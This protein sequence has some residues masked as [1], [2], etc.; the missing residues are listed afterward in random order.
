ML[1]ITKISVLFILFAFLQLYAQTPEEFIQKAEE[2]YR[3]NKLAEAVQLMEQAIQKYPD[4][5][6][7]YSYL[8]LYRGSQA[9][10]TQNF[11]EAGRLVGVGF[12]ML[13]KGV[14]LDSNNPIARFNRGLLAVKVPPFL[15]HLDVGIQDLEFLIALSQ[16][17][18]E[19]VPN[20]M[21]VAAHE[22][23]AEGYE[24]KNAPDKAITVLQK[25]VELAP[26]SA[27]AQKAQ[28][29][30]ANLK[31]PKPVEKVAE[32]KYTSEEVN[33][34]KQ[35]VEQDPDNSGLLTQLG[36]AYCDNKDFGNAE[37]VLNKA[38]SLD[39][40]NIGAYKLLLSTLGE[41]ADKGYDERIYHDTDLRTNLAFSV[42][43]LA[44]K[45]VKAA[46]QDMELRL[47]RGS[48]GVSMPFFVG[49]LE[50]GM[51]DLLM[52]TNSDASKEIKAEAFYW[53]GMGHQKKA[54][55]YWIK[56]IT[57]FAKTDATRM[58]F[59]SMR[60]TIRHFDPQKSQKPYVTI[61]FTLGYRDELAPQTAV[62][63]EDKTGNYVKTL[64]V[65]GFSAF[66]KE[67]QSNLDRWAKASGFQGTDGITGA[68]IDAGGHVYV[69]DLKNYLGKKV[70]NGE[71]VVKVE[72]IYWPSMEDQFVSTP[73]TV[74]LKD[75]RVVV[76]EG[77]ILPYLEV[78]YFATGK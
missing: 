46:P 21:L 14:E 5:S 20:G 49:K 55:T 66:A 42:A 67:K 24:K 32:K 10:Q 73:I 19:K 77:N 58:A 56:V 18:P 39:S 51:A 41:L 37:K 53:L 76:T 25:V 63:I 70:K 50:D 35:K 30:I 61:D 59:E 36:K 75:S 13:N 69:W 64:Y 28:Q 57:E 9:G 3:A 22:F 15:G 78:K 8:G 23:L 60:P 27:Q 65:S 7:A 62:W 1:R 72:T 6:S 33:T 29:T 17:S 68:S 26:S 54:N 4:N 43:K 48:V 74:G 38:I 2:N 52:V 40:T 47:I 34:L 16:K 71:Y 45:A 11:M 31:K 12:E 44:D